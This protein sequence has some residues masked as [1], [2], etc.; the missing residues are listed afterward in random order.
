MFFT[1]ENFVILRGFFSPFFEIL[2]K[3]I[4][5]I[6]T[7]A[8]HRLSLV[9]ELLKKLL[10]PEIV[11]PKKKKLSISFLLFLPNKSPKIEKIT[12]FLH[13]IQVSRHGIKGF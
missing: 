7:L 4:S 3:K 5:H 6:Y 2:K 1:H 11:F 8:V 13:F 12:L 9:A 10:Q